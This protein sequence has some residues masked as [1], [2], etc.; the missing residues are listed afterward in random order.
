MAKKPFLASSGTTF[1]VV[2]YQVCR[3]QAGALAHSSLQKPLKS[4]RFL[5]SCLAICSF[6]S[7]LRFSIRLRSGAWLGHSLT[8]MC[9]FF[10]HS[11]VALVVCFGSLSCHPRPI[12]DVL[13]EGRRLSSKVLQYMTLFIAPSV[14]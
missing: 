1:V 2:G 6:S 4:F 5:G 7:L 9:F 12:F 14:Q 11:F 3:F 13:A 10:S 8:L